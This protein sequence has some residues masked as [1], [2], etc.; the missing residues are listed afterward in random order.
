MSRVTHSEPGLPMPLLA[1][2]PLYPSLARCQSTNRFSSKRKVPNRNKTNSS[3]KPNTFHSKY[4]RLA[5]RKSR[6]E[7]KICLGFSQRLVMGSTTTAARKVVSSSTLIGP[8]KIWARTQILQPLAFALKFKPG[9][10]VVSHVT[11]K[12]LVVKETR[13]HAW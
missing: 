6:K 8:S 9:F 2:I 7:R 3:L 5:G 4:V 1:G 10:W 11:K 13:G 12:S